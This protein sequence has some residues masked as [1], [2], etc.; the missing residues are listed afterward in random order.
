[1][2]QSAEDVNALNAPNL[3]GTGVGQL[4]RWNRHVKVDAAVRAAGV[5]VVNVVGQDPFEVSSVP[6][7]DPIQAFGAD[8]AYPAFGVGVRLRRPRW[9]PERLDAGRGENCIERRGELAVAI[10]DQEPELGGALVEVHQQIPGRLGHPGAGRVGGDAGQVH[11]AV[12]EFD[13]E[14]DVQPGQPDRLDGE[15]VAGQRPGG[16][17]AQKLRPGWAAAS[18][19]WSEA[20]RRRMVRTEVADTRMPSLRHSPTMRR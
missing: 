5:V 17:G 4:D 1:M 19:R 20:V 16:L 3:V 14:Q 8:G 2:D 9:G 18:W 10:A 12:L 6:Y 7:Q 15:E 11:P 13:D